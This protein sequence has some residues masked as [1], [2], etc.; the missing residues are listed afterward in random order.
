MTNR[1]RL[2]Y[3]KLRF[4]DG[5][6]SVRDK[7]VINFELYMFDVESFKKETYINNMVSI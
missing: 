1:E 6:P 4:Y 2:M 5:V 7:Y 3:D